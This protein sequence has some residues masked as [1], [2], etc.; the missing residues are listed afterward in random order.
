MSPHIQLAALFLGATA[1]A[2]TACSRADTGDPAA[3]GQLGAMLAEDVEIHTDGG[4]KRPA[5]IKPLLG[6]ERVLR[7]LGVL[8]G[9]YAKNGSH[10]VRT[11]FINGLPGFVTREADG[12]LQTTALDIEDGRITAIYV[13][14]NPDKLRHL[15]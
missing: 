11:A 2:T 5:A 9:H 13:V 1:L 3:L 12:V 4:G 8:A 7:L 10:L 15:D 6:H 14:R